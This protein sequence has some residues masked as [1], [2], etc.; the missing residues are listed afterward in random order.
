MRGTRWTS[1][2]LVHQ[3]KIEIA[4]IVTIWTFSTSEI[5]ISF[6]IT[7]VPGPSECSAGPADHSPIRTQPNFHFIRGE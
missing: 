1:F 3:F 5:I 7:G 6:L 2:Y 4:L